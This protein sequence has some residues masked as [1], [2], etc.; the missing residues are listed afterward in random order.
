MAGGNAGLTRRL[1]LL[2]RLSRLRL[3]GQRL[4]WRASLGEQGALCARPRRGGLFRTT[5]WSVRTCTG[6]FTDAVTKPSD[7]SENRHFCLGSASPLCRGARRESR[8]TACASP[9]LDGPRS[10]SASAATVSVDAT[11][12]WLHSSRRVCARGHDA[13]GGRSAVVRPAGSA[14]ATSRVRAR[15][16]PPRSEFCHRYFGRNISG[17]RCHT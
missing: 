2:R 7:K 4:V 1:P 10:V 3:S 12:R 14:R 11:R 5:R 6:T 15:V 9:R 16:A 17:A 8:S 13:R